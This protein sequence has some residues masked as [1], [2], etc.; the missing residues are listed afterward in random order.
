MHQASAYLVLK[1]SQALFNKA[2]AGL[3]PDERQHV[4]RVAC[5]QWQIEQ[6]IL[7]TPEA[8]RIHLPESSVNQAIAEIRGRYA[9]R[10]EF[11][12][13]LESAGLDEGS[14]RHAVERDLRF[15]AVLERVGSL[16][17]PASDTDVEIFYLI[18]RQRFLRPENRTLSHILVTINEALP[19]SDRLSA[20]HKISEIQAML[21]TAP[22]RFADLALKHSECPTA[23]QGGFLGVVQRGQL[24][25]ELE[26]SAFKLRL[27]EL[28]EII[29][30]PMGF[31]LLRCEAMADEMQ[32]SFIAVREEIRNHLTERRKKTAQKR[33]IAGLFKPVAAD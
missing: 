10:D 13:D 16:E 8:A 30:S 22:S 11:L 5:R 19:G 21:A 17:S 3:A 29:E 26:A 33:W 15:E 24:Y 6:K 27:G 25:P 7:A 23:M 1:L 18:H 9:S 14:L 28:S 4:D 20:W 2:P 31:H 32:K 12:A